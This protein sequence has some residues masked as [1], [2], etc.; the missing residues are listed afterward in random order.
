[1]GALA[2]VTYKVFYGNSPAILNTFNSSYLL[3][4]NIFFI[5]IIICKDDG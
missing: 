3:I 4:Q 2:E 5:K 1:M